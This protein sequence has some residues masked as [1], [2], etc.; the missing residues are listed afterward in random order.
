MQKLLL[1]AILLFFTNLS[2]GQFGGWGNNYNGFGTVCE[3]CYASIEAGIINSTISGLDNSSA[4]TGFHIGFYQYK[5]F[6]ENF[7]M[8]SGITYNNIGAKVD[9]FDNPFIIHSIN[10]PLSL[11]YI[12][13]EKFQIF[14]GGEIGLNFF[15]DVPSNDGDFNDD[16]DLTD[17]LT[18]ADVSVFLGV[19]YI[20]NNNFDINL[21]Y[22]LG[23]TD[24]YN[25]AVIGFQEWKKNWFTLSVG[26][27]F[28][29]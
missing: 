17:I 6:S 19:G 21:R 16:Q 5:N 15:G 18:T 4:K 26:Y 24:I 14:G 7:A 29:D 20:I 3:D 9:G 23:L 8:R 12:F 13:K 11:H 2:F 25:G 27:T 28:R 22:N 1:L 10:T